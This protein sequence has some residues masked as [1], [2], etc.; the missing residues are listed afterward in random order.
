MFAV[1]R[2]KRWRTKAEEVANEGAGN[3]SDAR[4]RNIDPYVIESP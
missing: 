1:G 4:S 3:G 2:L